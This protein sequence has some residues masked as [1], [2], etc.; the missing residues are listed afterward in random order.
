MTRA[1]GMVAMLVLV[2]WPLSPSA[3]PASINAL[4]EATHFDQVKQVDR[5]LRHDLVCTCSTCDRLRLDE[6]PCG[7]ARA[8]REQIAHLLSERDVSTAADREAAYETVRGFFVER[9]GRAVLASTVVPRSWTAVALPIVG[10]VAVSVPFALILRAQ[11]RHAGKR[12][13]RHGR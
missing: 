7:E 9:Y 5:R 3:A 4:D 10:L 13:G 11:R 1:A 2:A 6:C 8:A 12:R